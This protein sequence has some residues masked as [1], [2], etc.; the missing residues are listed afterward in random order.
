MRVPRLPAALAYKLIRRGCSPAAAAA[1]C[2]AM[3]ERGGDV[4]AAAAA[5]A[6]RWVGFGLCWHAWP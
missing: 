3:P 5:D 1:G 2:S 6:M 4:V